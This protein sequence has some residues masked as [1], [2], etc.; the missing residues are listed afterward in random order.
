MSLQEFIKKLNLVDPKKVK[1]T[2]DEKRNA[3]KILVDSV[4]YYN[5]VPR[6]PFPFSRPYF[7]IFADKE[8][9]EV[10]AVKDYRE[11]DKD[12]R[13]ALEKMLSRIYFIPLIKKI[14]KIVYRA[15]EYVWLVETDRGEKE[16]VVRGRKSIQYFPGGRII[17][18]D[19]YDNVYELRLD[20]LDKKSMEYL[21]LIL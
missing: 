5:I 3:L 11:L 9:A 16:F 14:K 12:S 15:G 20:K 8:G 19:K 1:I 6:K 7:I 2:Y 10:C 21:A 17:I 4:K 13:E 18:F